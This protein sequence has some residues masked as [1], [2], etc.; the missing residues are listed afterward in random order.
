MIHVNHSIALVYVHDRGELDVGTV[1]VV[2]RK[3]ELVELRVQG[4]RR[5]YRVEQVTWQV[6]DETCEPA[7]LLYGRRFTC[8]RVALSRCP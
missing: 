6:N 3:S 1:A 4:Q 7:D 2:P 8:A 5:A